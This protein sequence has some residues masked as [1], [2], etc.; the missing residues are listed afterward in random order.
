MDNANDLKWKGEF[1]QVYFVLNHF[2]SFCSSEG[3]WDFRGLYPAQFFFFGLLNFLM[4]WEGTVSVVCQGWII[5]TCKSQLFISPSQNY[6]QWY[7][8]GSV[9]PGLM[10]LFT[11]GTV[12]TKQGLSTPTLR[13]SWCTFI[14]T[15]K[16][17]HDNISMQWKAISNI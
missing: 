9:K 17:Y 10:E 3:W 8:V 11:P 12:A 5:P 15:P 13:A 6:K 4:S 7:H 16:F 1:F 14:S 2:T